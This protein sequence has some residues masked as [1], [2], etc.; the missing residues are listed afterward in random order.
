MT[1]CDLVEEDWTDL[2]EEEIHELLENGPYRDAPVIKVSSSTG[3]GLED[4]GGTLARL[5]EEAEEES[6]E[7]LARLPI[8]RVFT[9]RGAG[10]VATGTLWTGSL[11]KGQGVRILPGE[12]E[13]RV[14]SLQLHGEGVSEAQAG[15]R[16][17]VG[18]SGAKTGHGDL[19]RGQTIVDDPAWEISWMLTCRLSLL[20]GTGWALEQGQRVRVH[21]GTAEVLARTALLGTERLEEGG[22]GWVQLRL[23]EPLLARGRDRL[24]IRSYSP[25]TT[26][27]GG[28]VVEVQPRK[29]RKLGEREDEEMTARLLGSPDEAVGALL[30]MAGWEGVP[31]GGLAQRTGLSSGLI[32]SLLPELQAENRLFEVDGRFFAREIGNRAEAGILSRLEEFHRSNPLR[33][34]LPLEEL[35]QTLPGTHGPNL[36]EA[37]LQ[38]L[39]RTGRVE[40]QG[41]AARLASFRPVLSSEERSLKSNLVRVLESAELAPPTVKELARELGEPP[42]LE[43]LLRILEEEGTL[44][45]LDSELYFHRQVV[46]S[47][48]SRL[49]REMAGKKDLGPARFRQVLPVTRKHLLP[50]LRYFDLVGVTTRMGEGRDVAAQ[51]PDG[52]G[53]NPGS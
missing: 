50:L 4:L 17:A 47:A 31:E 2:V 29:R 48:G 18:L 11:R 9:I 27:G 14:R 19:A 1:K 53:T 6:L 40:V 30:R 36:S 26:I 16:V 45:H 33:T 46:H 32:S 23:E 34:G 25:V 28:E 52:W 24:I 3:A 20:S 13:A 15:A 35:R 51:E 8:D 43:P 44:L 7:D 41:G 21:H 42:A 37:I 38:D 12:I 5:A 39:S 22:E 10:T 49:V